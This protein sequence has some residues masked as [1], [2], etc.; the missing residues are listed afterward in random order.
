M[1]RRGTVVSTG[2]TSEMRPTVTIQLDRPV[3]DELRAQDLD[4]SLTKHRKK[5]SVRQNAYY[6]SLLSECAGVLRIPLP[7]MHNR[8][9][10]EYGQPFAVDG[11]IVYIPF[12]DSEGT[13]RELLQA[14][15]YHVCPTS[16]VKD[17]NGGVTYRWYKLLRGSSDYNTA[18]M[19]RLVDGLIEKAKELGIET[20]T[21]DE[22]EQMRAYER[23]LETKR[24]EG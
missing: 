15:T 16:Y 14:T 8:I 23:E 11:K 12:E 1:R 13:E 5:R 20:M 7:E 4:I 2:Y 24:Q 3:N 18:E 19:S 21:P 22:L 9:L 6:W 17:G 10:R